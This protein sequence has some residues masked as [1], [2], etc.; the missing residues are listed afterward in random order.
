MIH[1]NS[2]LRE[3]LLDTNV[4]EMVVMLI[5]V[6]MNVVEPFI[7]RFM[8]AWDSDTIK[9]LSTTELHLNSFSTRLV[10]FCSSSAFTKNQTIRQYDDACVFKF[11]VMSDLFFERAGVSDM[12]IV[13][14][15]MTSVR[16][17]FKLP[18]RRSMHHGDNE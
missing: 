10:S 4:M 3:W 2:D 8:L 7:P 14:L 13:I 18:K 5:A 17:S 16:T 11:Y 12:V 9:A 6:T 15:T 1:P